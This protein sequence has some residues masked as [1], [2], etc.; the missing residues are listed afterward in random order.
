[1]AKLTVLYGH[2]TDTKAFEDY[3][4][5]TH[6]PIA[7]RI[8][9]VTRLELTVFAPGPDGSPPAYY[10]MAELYFPDAASMQAALAS[11]EGAAAANDLPNFASGGVTMLAGAVEG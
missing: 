1:M 8:P 3:Y 7:G 2:P 11:P 6:L 4:A 5:Q 9:S 10:R